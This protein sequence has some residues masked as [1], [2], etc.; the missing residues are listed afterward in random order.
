MDDVNRPL[1]QLQLAVAVIVI[2]AAVTVGI[3][4]PYSI[5]AA[6]VACVAAVCW[7]VRVLVSGHIAAWGDYVLLAVM[8]V[9]AGVS[10]APTSA[11]SIAP[12]AGSVII[13]GSDARRPQ[14]MRWAWPLSGFLAVGVGFLLVHSWAAVAVAVVVLGLAVVAAAARRSSE[15]TALRN[16]GHLQRE[17]A[18]ELIRMR[19]AAERVITPQRLRERFPRLTAREAEVLALIAHGE[20]ND[21]IAGELFITEA[22]VKSH[23][24]ALFSKLQS[25]DRVHAVAIVFGTARDPHESPAIEP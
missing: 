11:V 12:I 6:S 23:I 4:G 3:G 24:N 13:V 10:A 21:Q 14:W 17:H 19:A 9:G 7:I 5:V 1:V 22:T 25:R 18:A 20:A 8:L 16:L 15:Q 2:V